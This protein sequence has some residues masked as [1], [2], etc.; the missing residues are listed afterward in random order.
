MNY[1]A[2]LPHLWQSTLC[3]L[4]AWVLTL[5]L[6]NNRAAVRYWIW[7]AASVKFLISL[8]LLVSLGAQLGVRTAASST[9]PRL[10]AIV[11]QIS[12]PVGLAPV[13]AAPVSTA[14]DRLPAV[15]FALW[16]CG[17]AIALLVWFRSWWNIRALRRSATPL[18]LNLPVPVMSSTARL[19]PGVFGVFKPVLLL[20][21]GIA[22]RLTPDQLH[23]VVAHE[24][25]HVR[26]RDNLTAALHMLVE[27]LFWFHPLVWWIGSRLADERERA[28]DEAVLQSAGEPELYAEGILQVCRLYLESPIACMSGISGADL[29]LE[30]SAS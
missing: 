9:Q 7:L 22:N 13:I 11:N 28:C 15:L 6:R 18:D 3:V 16:L 24:L 12:A 26:R 1:A 8:S 30:F 10:S 2:L 27:T 23:T 17:A 25:Y 5:A 14:P 21:E 29:E 20:P 19:E 4:I